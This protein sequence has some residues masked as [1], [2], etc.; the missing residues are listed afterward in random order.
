VALVVAAAVLPVALRSHAPSRTA[1]TGPEGEFTPV[2]PARILDTRSGVGQVTPGAIDANGT[3]DVQVT[4]RGDVPDDGVSAVVLNVTAVS[5]TESGYLT[6][7]PTG[8]S[9]P[10][11]SNVSFAAGS[12]VSNMAT[13][14][15]GPDGRL[16][17]YN[18]LGSTHVLFD[19]VGYYASADGPAGARFT[20]VSPYRRFD[21]RNDWGLVGTSPIGPRGTLRVD[22]SALDSPVP[23]SGVTAVVLNVTVT[24]PTASGY[25][26]VMPAGGTSRTSSVN[27]TP[28][29][30][31]PNLVT[32][33]VSASGAV[34][35]YNPAGTTHVIADIVGYYGGPV[36][37]EAGRFVGIVPERVADTRAPG[38]LG[39]LPAGSV[40][41]VN[42]G[43]AG[44]VPSDTID[45]AVLNVTATQPSEAGYLAV[46]DDDLCGVPGW[47]NLAFAAGQTV[48]N[49]VV[50]GLSAPGEPATCSPF[51][52]LAPAPALVNAVGSTHY[53]VDVFGYF[54]NAS[55]G[56]SAL[57]AGEDADEPPP[58]GALVQAGTARRATGR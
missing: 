43:W 27:F 9:R 49:Q 45:A 38:S 20:S 40:D 18:A 24:D 11:V 35:F 17:A 56:A 39:P 36:D 46:S 1:A 12:V 37:G 16:S 32:V 3:I 52:E 50:T 7:Y 2:P 19:V 55:G 21:T 31:V 13:V 26:R 51:P 53:L 30:T 4:G 41:T 10:Q 48:A 33:P 25:L 15:V 29:Q 5:P 34:D 23:A 42:L 22:M 8:T 44:G 58:P 47:S 54:T 14:V 57:E 6:V 28:G